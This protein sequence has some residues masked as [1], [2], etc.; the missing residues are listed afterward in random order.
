[1]NELDCHTHVSCPEGWFRALETIRLELAG[2]A[3]SHLLSERPLQSRIQEMAVCCLTD[4][5]SAPLTVTMELSRN[6]R[7]QPGGALMKH[8]TKYVG[9]DV[10]QATTVTTVREETGRVLARTV[11]PTE[12]TAIVEWFRGMRGPVQVAFEEGTQAQWLHD[13]LV[14]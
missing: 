9:L 4:I 7:S 10:H 6:H 13:L 2:Y 3:T 11:L 5:E 12:A 8:S 14:P 1:M